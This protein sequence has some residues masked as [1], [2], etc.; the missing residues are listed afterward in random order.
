MGIQL[1]KLAILQESEG[2]RLGNRLRMR[3]IE[4]RK[5]IMKVYLAAQTLSSSVADAIEFCDKILNLSEFKGLGPTV[6]VKHT[7]R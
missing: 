1:E 7:S 4:Y 5:Q 6:S 2:L 3:N